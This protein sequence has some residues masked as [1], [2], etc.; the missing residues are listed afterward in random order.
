[1]LWYIIGPIVMAIVILVLIKVFGSNLTPQQEKE[2]VE[3]K[4]RREVIAKEVRQD[5]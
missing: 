2:K 3:E 1:M 4:K 5:V